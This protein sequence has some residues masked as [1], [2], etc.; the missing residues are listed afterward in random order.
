MSS[1]FQ[2]K[3]VAIRHCSSC[4]RESTAQDNF[5]RW[6]GTSQGDG[7]GAME[8][9][10]DDSNNQTTLLGK[11]ECFYESLAGPSLESLTRVV[12]AKTGPLHLNRFGMLVLSVL[13]AVPMWL[14]IVL[15]SP[16]DA[17]LSARAASS[18]IGSR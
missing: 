7:P 10:I 14:L 13:I 17:F 15:L 3:T 6:C 18:Q 1:S 11:G 16:I 2:A 9:E 5:C 12:K 8:P 4:D